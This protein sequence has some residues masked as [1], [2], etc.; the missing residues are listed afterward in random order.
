ML[1][2]CLVLAT[3]CGAIVC[4]LNNILTIA[5]FLHE[6]GVQVS[7]VSTCIVQELK[8][9]NCD[10]MQHTSTITLNQVY[11]PFFLMVDGTQNVLQR[12]VGW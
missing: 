2:Q 3:R 7:K 10:V 4:P 6:N 5:Q 1:G 8:Q 9:G 12:G 11:L